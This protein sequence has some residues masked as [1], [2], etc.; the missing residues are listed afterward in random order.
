M[1]KI[2]L[3]VAAIAALTG[4]SAWA[5]ERDVPRSAQLDMRDTLNRTEPTHDE[6]TPADRVWRERGAQ[7]PTCIDARAGSGGGDTRA[8][9]ERGDGRAQSEK[10]LQQRSWTGP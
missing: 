4:G 8:T 9:E 10:E 5:V 7:A 6:S 2:G 1:T 3:T